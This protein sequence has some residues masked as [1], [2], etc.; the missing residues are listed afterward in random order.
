MLE[1][2]KNEM[3]KWHKDGGDYRLGD[4]VVQQIWHTEGVCKG[5]YMWHVIVDGQSFISWPHLKDAKKSA[6]SLNKVVNGV[7]I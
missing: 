7:H 5:N 1:T 2:N 3:C 4:I 6:H